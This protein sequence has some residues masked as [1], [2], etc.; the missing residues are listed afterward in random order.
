MTPREPPPL[1]RLLEF[2]AG[3]LT[4][5]ELLAV[6]LSPQCEDTARKVLDGA[7]GIDRLLQVDRQALRRT[8]G[9]DGAVVGTL[10]AA[11][12]LVQRGLLADTVRPPMVD[13]ERI[14]RYLLARYGTPDQEIVGALYLDA[15]RRLIAE[16]P[17]FRGALG[18]ATVEPRQILRGALQYQAT[19]LI[20]W[21]TH[22]SGNLTPSPQDVTFTRRLDS[23]CRLVGIRLLD[24]LIIG[25]AGR[26]RPVET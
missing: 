22:P 25:A 7:G 12:E 4:D 16:R 17:V 9:L 8:H 24:H 3:A 6:I 21:H 13:P 5:A 20:V 1:E 11:T 26:W 2:G 10:A 14:A 19:N 15:D 18:H 23:A